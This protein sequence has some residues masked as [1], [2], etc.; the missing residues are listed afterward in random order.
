MLQL[1]GKCSLWI[2]E[3]GKQ[4]LSEKGPQGGSPLLNSTN[5]QVVSGIMAKSA[6]KW[7]KSWIGPMIYK[8][9]MLPVH[10]LRVKI[11]MALTSLQ[12]PTAAVPWQA[13]FNMP[14]R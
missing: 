6:V 10:R 1:P 12:M 2:I 7:S 5:D 9:T 14:H 4:V 13:A 11:H 8:F 3:A